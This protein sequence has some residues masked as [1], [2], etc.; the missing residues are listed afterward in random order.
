MAS[1]SSTFES[2]RQELFGIDAP[3]IVDERLRSARLRE[4]LPQADDRK[5]FWKYMDE[6]IHQHIHQHTQPLISREDLIAVI[7]TQ[8]LLSST[9]YTDLLKRMTHMTVPWI[10]LGCNSD[11]TLLYRIAPDPF[12]IRPHDLAYPL[13]TGDEAHLWPGC[14]LGA[15]TTVQPR[16]PALPLNRRKANLSEQSTI[17]GESDDSDIPGFDFFQIGR[18]EWVD[19]FEGNTDPSV[20]EGADWEDTGFCVVARLS[21]TGYAQGIYA[22]ADM[23]PYND[24]TGERELVTG[25]HWGMPPRSNGLQFSCAQIG[26]R[27]GD[28][29]FGFVVEW[30]CIVDH[31]VE[32]VP[33]RTTVDGRAIRVMVDEAVLAKH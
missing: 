15:N 3:K 1:S 33:L 9:V 11:R 31:P 4:L 16:Q 21:T 26:Q 13:S 6:A 32:L 22:V 7:D 5:A 23:W 19:N 29:G 12:A 10:P 27:L 24:E 18:L 14:F 28:M 17:S 20:V 8:R 30:T 25:P 2:I